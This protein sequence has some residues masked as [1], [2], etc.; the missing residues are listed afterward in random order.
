MTPQINWIKNDPK[1]HRFFVSGSVFLVAVMVRNSKTN[2]EQWEFDVIQIA[3]DEDWF[4]LEYR[5]G[6][7]FDAWEW[8][9]VEYFHLIEGEMP[10][11]SDDE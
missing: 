10:K 1:K 2:T 5:T 9:D 3:C 7:S 4:C 6:E 11:E 8:S